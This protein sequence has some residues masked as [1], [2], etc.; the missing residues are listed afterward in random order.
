MVSLGL[1]GTRC[2]AETVL[3]LA[4]GTPILEQVSKPS[5]LRQARHLCCTVHVELPVE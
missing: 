4:G 1:R 2:V 5:V 3:S